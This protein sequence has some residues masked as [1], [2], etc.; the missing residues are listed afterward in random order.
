VQVNHVVPDCR[1]IPVVMQCETIFGIK[2]EPAYWRGELRDMPIG[3]LV[4]RVWSH[5]HTACIEL[6]LIRWGGGWACSS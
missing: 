5:L 3:K 4:Y 1:H 2:M 6:E